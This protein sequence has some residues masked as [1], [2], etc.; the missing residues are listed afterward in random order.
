MSKSTEA[1]HLPKPPSTIAE[2]LAACSTVFKNQT[3][4]VE[5]HGQDRKSLS[6]RKMAQEATRISSYLLQSG[7]K[8]SDRIALLSENRIEWVILALAV[9]NIGAVLVPL[10]TNLTN[11]ELKLIV[12][13]SKVKLLCTSRSFIGA[14][15]ASRDAC[16]KPPLILCFDP[17]RAE[18]NFLIWSHLQQASLPND[19]RCATVLPDDTALIVFTSGTTSKPKAVAL[20]HRNILSSAWWTFRHTGVAY[21]DARLFFTIPLFHMFSLV[22]GLLTPLMAGAT[23]ILGSS[24]KPAQFQAE[25]QAS[26]PT[27]LIGVPLIFE[28]MLRSIQEGIEKEP[29]LVRYFL[30]AHR[31]LTSL[32]GPRAWHPISRKLYHAVHE[33]LGGQMKFI[34]SGGGPLNPDVK[35]G[36]E[37]MGFSVL[38]GY[39]L[40]ETGPV[41]SS[42]SIV[43]SRPG[44]VGKVLSHL[45]VR[46]ADPDQNG[47][48]EI[49]VKGDGVMPG[50]E[51]A[52]GLNKKAFDKK[53]LKTGDLGYLDRDGFLF[54]RGRNKEL[55]V[56]SGGKNIYP[57]ELEKIYLQSPWIKEI[58]IF[59]KVGPSGYEGLRATV[60]ANSE[61]STEVMD[62]GQVH[63]IIQRELED[64]GRNL[65]IFKRIIQFSLSKDELPKTSM[66][67]LKRYQIRLQADLPSQSQSQEIKGPELLE[68]KRG[69][70]ARPR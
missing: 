6:Y 49:W 4:I 13:Q 5:H 43:F 21:P 2:F 19:L 52:P 7:I 33:R 28:S 9:L 35:L 1:T 55:I 14:A 67:K 25:I 30:K 41:I 47:I 22:T 59:E 34:V 56:T 64:I 51:D 40:T 23:S 26:K 3:A 29:L 50:Y 16:G 68:N 60:V 46:I 66:K 20:T 32:K 54:I 8:K 58:C 36:L 48:G 10:D 63:K 11:E 17:T 44:S 70:R 45:K 24:L 27:L 53:W 18:D 39:G 38:Q 12:M 42:E 65:P 37:S 57:E 15:V 31:S 62:E 69:D 61:A